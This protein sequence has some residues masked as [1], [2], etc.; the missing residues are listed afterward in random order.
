MLTMEVAEGQL[1]LDTVHT[2][3]LV[4]VLNAV[5][6]DE[7]LFTEVTEPDPAITDHTPIPTVG[8]TAANVAVVAQIVWFVPASEVGCASRIIVT[9]EEEVQAPFETVHTKE[10]VP[11][12]NDVTCDEGLF[13]A[14]MLPDPAIT[15]QTPVPTVGLTAAKVA[16]VAQ[17]V[18][19]VPALDTGCASRT[20]VTVAALVG[21][22]LFGIVHT[23]ELVPVLN[24]VTCE[25]GL[26]IEVT[27]P[28]PDNTDQVPLPIAFNVAEDAQTV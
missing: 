26:L 22:L 14:V 24:D 28:E 12:L 2:N 19:F 5:I 6:C 7:G 17:I 10:L 9:V 13:T 27:L 8:F 1:P 18:W 3:E 20:I 11:V 25:V 4:P 23:K 16:V 21:Q 15:D